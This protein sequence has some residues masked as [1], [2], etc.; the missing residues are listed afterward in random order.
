MVVATAVHR[1]VSDPRV[2]AAVVRAGRKRSQDFSL[3]AGAKR[4]A[5]AVAEAV[6]AGVRLGHA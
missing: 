5:L 1:M 6:N 4:M 2:R 3:E